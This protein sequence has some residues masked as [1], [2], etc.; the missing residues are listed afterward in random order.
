MMVAGGLGG[1]GPGES[2]SYG[3]RV[4]VLKEEKKS[5][6]WVIVTTAQYYECV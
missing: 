2:L 1:G 6:R 4:S 3:Y 5:W